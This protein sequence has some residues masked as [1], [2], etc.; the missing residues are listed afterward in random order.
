MKEPDIEAL[1]G[2]LPEVKPSQDFLRRVRSIPLEHARPPSW[3]LFSWPF[4][5]TLSA[6]AGALAIGFALGTVA[7]DPS[8]D[9]D[10]L[11]VLL[12]ADSGDWIDLY[13]EFE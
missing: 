6:L 8:G 4:G 1:F 3:N 5:R 11:A 7:P 9:E 13:G 2:A 12:E 10:D